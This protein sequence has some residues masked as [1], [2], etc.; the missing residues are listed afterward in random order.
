MNLVAMFGLGV[1]V[2]LV[3]ESIGSFDCFVYSLKRNILVFGT[4][5]LCALNSKEKVSLILMGNDR[6]HICEGANV[7]K[8]GINL[9]EVMVLETT[10]INQR[11]HR[12]V[13]TTQDC[14]LSQDEMEYSAVLRNISVG[15]AK[16]LIKSTKM[17]VLGLYDL[18]LILDEEH[19][20]LSSKVVDSSANG[21]YISF[22]LCFLDVDSK[23]EKKL[24]RILNDLEIDMRKK[25][26][27]MENRR[28]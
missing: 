19:F 25:N 3:K 5:D 8:V 16:V 26:K 6:R 21:D 20:S 2:T 11:A 7:K 27:E 22:N 12:R 28:G 23:V 9:Y 1:K 4:E 17:S 15:G 24:T 13:N 10:N 14:V 18:K